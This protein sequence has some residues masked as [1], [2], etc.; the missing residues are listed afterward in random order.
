MKPLLGNWTMRFSQSP[1][2]LKKLVKALCAIGIDNGLGFSV[3]VASSHDRSRQDAAPTIKET[4]L[5]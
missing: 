4:R 5:F 1:M 3:G 2:T